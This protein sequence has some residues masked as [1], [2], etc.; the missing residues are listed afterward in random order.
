[1]DLPADRSTRQLTVRL[2]QIGS[3]A[4]GASIGLIG[5]LVVIAAIRFRPDEASGSTPR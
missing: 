4:K 1:M 2:G 5:A 3:I